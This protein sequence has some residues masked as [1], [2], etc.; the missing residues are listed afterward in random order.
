MADQPE[1]NRTTQS[2][3]PAG[4]LRIRRSSAMN[5]LQAFIDRQQ[6]QQ[7]PAQSSP[8]PYSFYES[9]S[10]VQTFLGSA[11]PGA[12]T[13]NAPEGYRGDC[14]TD[15]ETAS[16]YCSDPDGDADMDNEN[17]VP[18]YGHPPAPSDPHLPPAASSA[19]SPFDVE[20]PTEP[21]PAYAAAT[22]PQ[23]GISFLLRPVDNL[24]TYMAQQ[25]LLGPGS[26]PTDS[27]T[28]AMRQPGARIPV[29]DL[30]FGSLTRPSVIAVSPPMVMP[31]TGPRASM[32]D[33]VSVNTAFA[34]EVTAAVRAAS[35]ESGRPYP[36]E[37]CGLNGCL[38]SC[39]TEL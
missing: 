8:P 36:P 37:Y 31:A 33:S 32:S 26:R 11:G 18:D 5:S 12:A 15:S 4:A 9:P 13:N 24:E 29:S 39:W 2:Q 20:P 28:G 38:W 23:T 35:T 17:E 6:S 3:Q 14:E 22:S 25:R 21:L 16:T 1:D 7:Q 30:A 34:A 19:V 27:R 10:A